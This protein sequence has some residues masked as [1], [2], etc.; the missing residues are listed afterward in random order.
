MVLIRALLNYKMS[1]AVNLSAS[2]SQTISA[3]RYKQIAKK[4]MSF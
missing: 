4:K 1:M 2:I 3:F